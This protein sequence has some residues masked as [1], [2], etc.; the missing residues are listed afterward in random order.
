M[1][2]LLTFV[3]LVIDL[4]DLYEHDRLLQT[5]AD[6]GA[7]A[8]AQELIRSGGSIADA[9]TS[10]RDYVDRNTAVSRVEAANLALWTPDV[11]PRSVEVDLLEESI[12]FFFARV[13]GSTEG[14]VRAHAKAEVMYLTSVSQL[15]PLAIP[16]M[17][18]ENFRVKYRG[19]GI[20]YTLSNPTAGDPKTDA[21]VYN[22]YETVDP[23]GPGVYF[24]DLEALSADTPSEV[25]FTWEGVGLWRIFDP[26]VEAVRS[27]DISRS[28][29]SFSI[30]VHADGDLTL[31]TLSGRVG[32]NRFDLT[33]SSPEGAPEALY[34]A[35]GVPIP[36]SHI[37]E[38]WDIADLTLTDRD[39]NLIDD[40]IARFYVSRL[41]Y[42]IYNFEQKSPA[43]WGWPSTGGQTQI[44]SEVTVR[45]LRFEEP[46]TMKVSMNTSGEW[47]GNE[48]WA[49]IYSDASN[50]VAELAGEGS[51]PRFPL[52]IGSQ[53]Q[54]QPGDPIGQIRMDHLVGEIVLVPIVDPT[55][56]HGTDYWR[57]QSF[58][59]F[60]IDSY[61]ATGQE[62][63]ING[64]FVRWFD[65]GDW[66]KD[67][68]P[69]L[70]IE[71][72]VLTE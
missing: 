10:A 72:A 51:E 43:G 12:P 37:R 36:T 68:P 63:S 13:I 65:T 62:T 58:A 49:D 35:D 8:G 15:L 30:A 60:R 18:P 50:L 40:R 6:A 59:A 16:Y 5:A 67:P 29:N 64:E 54:S 7:L 25:L 11:T 23:P 44:G 57:I 46:T 41:P 39:L 53:L 55:S 22:G 2:A 32:G 47:S 4:G 71:T 38:G 21:G 52:E 9:T 3:A 26:A 33:R 1:V 66:Q 45:V 69:G 14:R 28:G 19:A 61:T 34:V 27:V 56:I 31:S 20:D 42:P 24:I 70:Y 17:H 48:F